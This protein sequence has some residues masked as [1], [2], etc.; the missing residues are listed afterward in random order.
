MFRITSTVTGPNMK[1]E[2]SAI[3]GQRKGKSV[4]LF[5]TLDE[6]SKKRSMGTKL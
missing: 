6:G 5:L 1:V 3:F 4:T 2:T